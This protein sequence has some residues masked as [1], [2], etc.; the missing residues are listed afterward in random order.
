M[1]SSSIDVT[2]IILS[3]VLFMTGCQQKQPVVQAESGPKI[4][5]KILNV[6]WL[7]DD[8]EYGEV[9]R[10]TTGY[11]KIHTMSGDDLHCDGLD[12]A[13]TVITSVTKM[14]ASDRAGAVYIRQRVYGNVKSYDVTFKGEGKRIVYFGKLDEVLE[15]W[16]CRRTMEGFN[17][18][19]E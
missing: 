1:A 14:S 10:C 7:T 5:H 2:K 9:K 16:T 18:E 3:F 11:K 8:W 4:V 17:C 19:G 12:L 15:E 6:I 13:W